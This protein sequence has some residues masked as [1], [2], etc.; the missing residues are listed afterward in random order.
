MPSLNLRA[1][2]R[3]HLY[4]I[5]HDVGLSGLHDGDDGVGAYLTLLISEV[6]EVLR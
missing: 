5:F 1:F 6:F 4:T 3:C 2:L